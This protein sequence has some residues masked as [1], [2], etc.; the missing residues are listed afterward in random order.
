MLSKEKG[1]LQ[2]RDVIKI[3]KYTDQKRAKGPKHGSRRK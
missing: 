1:R 3:A 2:V